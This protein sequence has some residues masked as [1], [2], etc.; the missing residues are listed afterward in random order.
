[1]GSAHSWA[2]SS[3]SLIAC[4]QQLPY[5]QRLCRS[6]ISSNITRTNV[7]T[8][9]SV[10][11]SIT[12][13]LPFATAAQQQPSSP[14]ENHRLDGQFKL[15]SKTE[16]IPAN[17]KNAFCKITRE[18]SFAMANPGETFQADDVVIDRTLP[19]RRLV[20]AA[21]QDDKWFVHYER[22]GYGHSYYVTAFKLSP[23]GDSNFEWGCSVL[24]VAKTLEELRTMVATC[25]L[26]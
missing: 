17:V 3:M 9:R 15:V 7:Q 12:C 16:A 20:F 23:H 11:L 5:K 24:H 8:I 4:Y 2:W 21:A 22:G 14:T 26:A 25:R 13:C 1:M 19:W 6:R 18:P 10:I